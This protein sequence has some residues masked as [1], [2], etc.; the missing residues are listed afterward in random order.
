[1]ARRA[2]PSQAEPIASLTDPTEA[3][4]SLNVALDTKEERREQAFLLA[5]RHIAE[6][7]SIAQLAEEAKLSRE[8]LYRTLSAKGNPRLSTLVVLLD[9]LGLRLRIKPKAI[10]E[11]H[12]TPPHLQYS[13]ETPPFVPSSFPPRTPE[14]S[15][16]IKVVLWLTVER[17]SKFVRGKKRAREDIEYYVLRHYDMK[18]RWPDGNEYELT[19]SY[20]TDEELDDII[21]R[22]IL[23]EASSQADLRNCFIEADVRAL[24]DSDRSW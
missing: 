7:Y 8:S 6:V 21:Y 3:A 23:Q 9:V 16:V 1:M 19:I 15:K 5:L 20:D 14:K 18:K 11:E 12:P 22:D 4:A 13:N 24:D 2:R 10:R 17:N